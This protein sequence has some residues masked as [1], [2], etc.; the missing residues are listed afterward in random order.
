MPLN[1]RQISRL[2]R[3]AIKQTFDAHSDYIAKKKDRQRVQVS[4]EKRIVGTILG[5]VEQSTQVRSEGKP[6]A[7]TM[8]ASCRDTE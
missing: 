6:S 5:Y 1:K 2:V 4:L 3:G 8:V 7:D